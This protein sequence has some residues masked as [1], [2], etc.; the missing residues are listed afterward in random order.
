MIEIR[1]EQQNDYDAVR[2]INDQ[3]FGQPDEGRIVDT[4]RESCTETVSLIAVSEH[5]IIGLLSVDIFHSV[6]KLRTS[7]I[8]LLA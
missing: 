2:C 8:A 1:E 3:A 7:F 5:D 4:L 6:Q